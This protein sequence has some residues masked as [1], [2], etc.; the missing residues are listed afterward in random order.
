MAFGDKLKKIIGDDGE[1]DDK[2]TSTDEY[3]KDTFKQA[4]GSGNKMILLEPRAFSEAQTIADYLKS[5]NTVV[6]NLKRVTPEIAKRVVDFLSGA[7]Y[8]IGGDLQKLG[9]G[10]FLCTP[11][12]VNVEGKITGEEKQKAKKAEEKEEENEFDW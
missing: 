6:V 12:N 2:I 4:G 3:Y 7:V 11:N 9:N 8:A 10:I 1:I 5:R